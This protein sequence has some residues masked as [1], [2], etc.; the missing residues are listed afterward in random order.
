VLSTTWSR[1]TPLSLRRSGSTCTCN[2]RER[3]P[4]TAT[5]ATPGTPSNFGI[6]VQRARTDISI[7]ETSFDDSPMIMARLLTDIGCSMFGGFETLGIAWAMMSRSWTIWRAFMMS[8]PG[9]KTRRTDESP[10][11]D[12]D[13]SDL[14]QGTPLS[15]SSTLRVTSSSTS[16]AASPKASVW[17]SIMGAPNSGRTSTGASRNR[18]TPKIISPAATARTRARN[19]K[20]NASIHFSMARLLELV[21]HHRSSFGVLQRSLWLDILSNIGAPD[22]DAGLGTALRVSIEFSHNPL[23]S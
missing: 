23:Q 6:I 15:S 13:R 22:Y 19:R 5:F 11:T 16:V 1:L 10:W 2:W 3:M 17:I 14:T 8:V 9:S 18:T 4:Q 7:R 20:L 12:F 21:T